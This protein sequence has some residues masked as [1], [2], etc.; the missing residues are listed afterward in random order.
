MKYF[1][2]VI[3]VFFYLAIQA[4]SLRVIVDSKQFHSPETGSYVEFYAQFLARSIHFQGDSISGFNAAISMQII[5]FNEDKIVQFDKFRID[6]DFKH[7]DYVE[8]IYGLKRFVLAPGEYAVEYEFIDLNNV[9]DTIQ[10]VQELRVARTPESSFFS[11]VL[12]LESLIKTSASNAFVRNGFEMLPRLMTY[13]NVESERMIT[14]VELYNTHLYEDL[15]RFALRYYLRDGSNGKRMD[16]YTVT[17]VYKSAEVVPIIVN[18]NIAELSSGSYELVYEFLDIDETILETRHLEFDR[19]N[20]TYDDLAVDYSQTVVDP[21]F[22]EALPDDSMFFYLE[23]LTPI[24]S[25]ADISQ[26]YSIIDSKNLESAKKYFQSYWIRT[27]PKEPTD[28]WIKYKKSVVAVQKEYGTLLLPG[29]KSDRGRVFLQYGPP[30]A[31]VQRPNEP[32][33]YPYEIWQYYKIGNFSNRRFVFYNPVGV[34]NEYMLLHSD[35]PGELFNNRWLLD[36]SRTGMPVNTRVNDE[37]ILEGGR[38]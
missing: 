32:G 21:R 24:S 11:E 12:P 14:Y 37:G 20:P 30:S 3:L 10:F 1:F 19:F 2:S 7:N 4:K 34:G 29:Y 22:F 5:I 16:N 18:M 17:K 23:S 38:R 26:I 31:R 15:P 8:D 33:E 27:N 25:Q 36:L 28:A 6:K 35:L 13:Y 9:K